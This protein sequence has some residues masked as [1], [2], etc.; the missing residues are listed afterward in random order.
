M[1]KLRVLCLNFTNN[2]IIDDI[3]SEF[4]VISLSFNREADYS[5]LLFDIVV[6]SIKSRE[7]LDIIRFLKEKRKFNNIPIVCI[8][9]SNPENLGLEALKSGCD[10]YFIEP[11]NYE[12]LKIKINLILK[13]SRAISKLKLEMLIPT[14]SNPDLKLTK[15]ERGLLG[16]LAEGMSNNDISKKLYLSELTVKTHLKNIF[17]KLHVSNRTEAVLVGLVHDL[18]EVGKN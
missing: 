4:E 3:K 17:K 15:R 1:K 2:Q 12:E 8:F 11:V 18:I 9:S 7:N 13:F 10:D 5:Q 16:L 14:C 6:L